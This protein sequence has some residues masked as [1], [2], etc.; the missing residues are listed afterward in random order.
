MKIP[1]ADL[2]RVGNTYRALCHNNDVLMVDRKVVT[3]EKFLRV[4]LGVDDTNCTEVDHGPC[5]T[6][7]YY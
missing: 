6:Y 4:A 2:D 3:F 5:R 7:A 1:D